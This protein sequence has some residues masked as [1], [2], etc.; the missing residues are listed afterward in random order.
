MENKILGILGGMGPEAT[1][2]FYKKIIDNTQVNSD[3]EHIDIVIYSHASMP[4]RTECILCGE[5]DYLWNIISEDIDKLKVMGSD[6]LAIPCNTCHYFAE[7]LSDKMN[8]KFIN[9]IQETA[10]FAT[11]RNIKKAGILATDGTVKSNFYR[12]AFQKNG[13]ETLYPSDTMQREVMSLIYDQ[14]KT[15]Q[16]G[17]KHQ[18]MRIVQELREAGC[19]AV[20]LGCTELSVFN[21]NYDLDSHYYIDALDVL[22][23]ECIIRC[24]GNYCC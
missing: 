22:A 18:F 9:M 10:K 21:M 3:R 8:G 7:K 19:D 2:V 13:I 4:D 6:Y 1:Q 23:K 20:V 15:G 11:E 5:A 17:D 12:E 14:I 16:K 24:G